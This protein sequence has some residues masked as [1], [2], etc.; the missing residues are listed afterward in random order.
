M[1]PSQ[2][3]SPTVTARGWPQGNSQVFSQR[4]PWLTFWLSWK[5]FKWFNTNEER[6]AVDLTV[7]TFYITYAA[8]R[9]LRRVRPWYWCQELKTED[10]RKQ[11]APTFLKPTLTTCEFMVNF[12]A[13]EI[14]TNNGTRAWSL[15]QEAKPTR[16]AARLGTERASACGVW[17]GGGSTQTHLTLSYSHTLN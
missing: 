7:H 12:D 16:E 8:L 6:A 9:F 15:G 17:R 5:C 11:P 1:S 2:C 4:W 3:L 10:R 13:S 14:L